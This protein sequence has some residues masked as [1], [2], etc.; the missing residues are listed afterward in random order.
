VK[1]LASIFAVCLCMALWSCS[2][3][4][5]APMPVI[6]A[7]K[8]TAPPEIKTPAKASETET[9]AQLRQAKDAVRA[10]SG[11]LANW[12]QR[13]LTLT[14][15]RDQERK[16]AFLGTLRA[17]CLWVA[18]IALLG[19]LACAVLAFVSPIAKTTLAKVAIACGALVVLAT[20]CAWAVPWLP[21][22]GVVSLII[23]VCVL[24]VAAIVAAVRW[25]PSFAHAAIHAADGYQ[26]A[27]GFLRAEAP[28][29][30]NAL[31]SENRAMQSAQGG[32][33]IT[34]GDTLHE[35]ARTFRKGVEL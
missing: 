20:G 6:E 19:A 24:I 27:V 14:K 31:D 8:M 12:Q 17:S 18:G 21:A 34:Q 1:C 28:S 35:L 7:P 29:I 4:T 15:D 30:A 2:V 23:L 11:D 9:D 13:V 22:V 32:T 33:V 25:F 10:L 26:Q 5:I 3:G 16:E